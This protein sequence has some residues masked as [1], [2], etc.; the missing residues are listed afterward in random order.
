MV[1]ISLPGAVLA[2]PRG[3]SARPR[4]RLGASVG[5]SW[6]PFWDDFLIFVRLFFGTFFGILFLRVFARFRTN[7][8]SIWGSILCDFAQL[9]LVVSTPRKPSACRSDQ[10]SRGVENV[11]K[12]FKNRR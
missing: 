11:L 1:P 6:G 3:P 8:A 7:F 5:V 10:G 2:G 9:G 12:C 4:V